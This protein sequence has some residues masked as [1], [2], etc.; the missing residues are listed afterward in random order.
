MGIL[1]KTGDDKK[2]AS[3][4]V[5]MPSNLAMIIDM[6]VGTAYTSR[7]DFVID[8]IR[9]FVHYI[10]NEE[11]GIMLY[12]QEKEDAARDVKLEFYYETIKE[13]TEMYRN[14]IVSAAEKSQ[15]KDVDILLS[16]PKGLASQI[17]R[18]VERTKC[19]RNH[20]EFIKAGSC[21]LIILLGADNTNDMLTA[22]FLESNQST[23]DLREQIDKMKKEMEKG[24][25]DADPFANFPPE[26]KDD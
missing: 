8:G 1:S 23:K 25:R 2:N 6:S 12:L 13:K 3:I 19:F 20:Q 14:M 11:A 18:L 21:Y 10:N 5:R 24:R 9:R 17:D 16:L 26:A 7:P 22:S 15:K 4:M